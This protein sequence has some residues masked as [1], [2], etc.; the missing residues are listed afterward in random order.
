VLRRDLRPPASSLGPLNEVLRTGRLTARG[1]DRVLRVA[2]TL[3]DLAS[4]DAPSRAD[5]AEAVGIRL[6]V[7]A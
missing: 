4:R 2:W 1:A 6:G 5:V 7:P 3:A